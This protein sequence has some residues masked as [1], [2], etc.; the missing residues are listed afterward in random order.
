MKFNFQFVTILLKPPPP[1][2]A[3]GICNVLTKRRQDT[4]MESDIAGFKRNSWWRFVI[5]QMT[6]I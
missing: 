1:Q 4:K 6:A 3:R 5:S 2:T